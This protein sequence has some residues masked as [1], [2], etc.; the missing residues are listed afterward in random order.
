MTVT[1]P[2]MIAPSPNCACANTAID[3]VPS[4]PVTPPPATTFGPVTPGPTG[5]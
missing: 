5:Q 2:A 4:L 1:A 3:T